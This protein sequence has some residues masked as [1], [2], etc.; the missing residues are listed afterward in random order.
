MRKKMAGRFG[1]KPTHLHP[2]TIEERKEPTQ[3]RNQ[4]PDGLGML[5][6]IQAYQ[7]ELSSYQRVQPGYMYQR[8]DHSTH[9]DSVLN[10]PKSEKLR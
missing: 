6:R 2:D 3:N 7:P 8:P 4:P 9:A 1:R 10:N 5:G